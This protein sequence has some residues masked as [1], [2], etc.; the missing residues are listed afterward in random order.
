MCT[1]IDIQRAPNNNGLNTLVFY[2]KISNLPTFDQHVYAIGR[3][4]LIQT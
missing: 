1:K 4:S 2:I 3:I